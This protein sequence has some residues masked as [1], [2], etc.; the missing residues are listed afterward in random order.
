M[1]KMTIV[2]I[3]LLV[4]MMT[5][6]VPKAAEDSLGKVSKTACKAIKVSAEECPKV[7]D[8]LKAASMLCAEVEGTK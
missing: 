3:T 1:K 5:G 7:C 2:T 4:M 6:C 8:K